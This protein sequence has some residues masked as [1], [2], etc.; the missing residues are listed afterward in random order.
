MP[1]ISQEAFFKEI[2]YKPHKVQQLYHA[3]TARYNIAICGRRTGKS[4]MGGNK[5]GCKLMNDNQRLWIV[6]PTYDLAEKEFRVIWDSV[7]LG[8]NLGKNKRVKKTYNVKQGNMY[9]EMP[10]KSRIEC[11]TAERPDLLVGEGL[12]G[13]ILSEAAKHNK[14]TWEKYLRPTLTDRRGIA[15]FLTTPE[16][17]NWLY[18]LY[19]LGLSGQDDEYQSFCFPSWTNPYVYPGGIDDPEIVKL[20]RDTDPVLFAQ[21]YGAEFTAFVG[22]IYMDFQPRTHVK[23]FSFHP[24]W[25]N[26]IAFDFGYTNP[27][28]AIEF[29]VD[30]W[31]NIWIWREHYKAQ[32][33]REQHI[34]ALVARTNP[35]GYHL[36]LAFGDAA[37]PEACE[38]ISQHYVPCIGDPDSKTDWQSGVNLVNDFVR[39]QVV[40]MDDETGELQEEPRLFV[41]PSCEHTIYE[42]TN[43]KGKRPVLGRNP[44]GPREAAI[45]KDNH[46]MD[47]IRY[48][49]VHLYQLGIHS[50]IEHMNHASTYPSK[51]APGPIDNQ[52]RDDSPLFI[53]DEFSESDTFVNMRMDF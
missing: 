16:G 39:M 9:I 31:D 17:Q 35:V 48:A 43:Y 51:P 22:K 45:D 52:E 29:Q 6:G 27:F 14:E 41:H 37:D 36:D 19:M 13:I 34:R 4:Y 26:Y 8:M 50:S 46:A 10:W 12:D 30:P 18:P 5:Y 23:A 15:D 32:M 33:T 42:F 53:P 3:S 11:R 2:S 40:G 7:I 25:K 1:K 28:A 21:E 38:Y 20:R 44:T 47:A 49:L 24:E